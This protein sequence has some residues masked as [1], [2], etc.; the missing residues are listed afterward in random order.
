[1]TKINRIQ[2]LELLAA[3]AIAHDFPEVL[4]GNRA[5]AERVIAKIDEQDRI[6]TETTPITE[7]LEIAFPK[8]ND[9]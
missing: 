6:I 9:T 1:M 4:A 7:M 5:F 2:A 8:E 3:A